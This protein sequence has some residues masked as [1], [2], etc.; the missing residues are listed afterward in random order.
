MRTAGWF[1]AGLAVVVFLAFAS[2][3][4]PERWKLLGWFGVGVGALAGYLLGRIARQ[5]QLGPGWVLFVLAF[6]LILAGQVLAAAETYRVRVAWLQKHFRNLASEEAEAQQLAA[7][8]NPDPVETGGLPQVSREEMERA[9]LELL[10]VSR[11]FSDRLLNVKWKRL[12]WMH[13]PPWPAALWSLEVLLAASVGVWCTS[14][15]LRQPRPGVSD[16]GPASG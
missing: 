11:F 13:Q 5:M 9:R 4:V 1:L 6:L 7:E 14:R 16:R 2:L 3:K 15:L 10:S 12:D 8:Q